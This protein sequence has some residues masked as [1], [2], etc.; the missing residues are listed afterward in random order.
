[1][2]TFYL[3]LGRCCDECCPDSI[4]QRKVKVEPTNPCLGVLPGHNAA[5]PPGVSPN[6]RPQVVDERKM[7]LDGRSV[8][9]P[10]KY[11]TEMEFP[12]YVS[13]I[14]ICFQ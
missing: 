11:E 10:A 3:L 7:T 6:R 4:L 8:Q 9:A 1:M 2:N 14:K 13:K 12:K 5:V